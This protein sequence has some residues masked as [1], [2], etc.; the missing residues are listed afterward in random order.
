MSGLG[1]L[2]V[3]RTIRVRVPAST[4]NL[5]PGFDSIGLALGLWDEYLVTALDAPGLE[6][7]VTGQGSAD[8][9]TDESHLVVR[10][11]RHTWDVLEATAP[12]GLRLEAANGV[13]H[14]RGLGSSATAIVAGVVAA[15]AFSYAAELTPSGDVTVDLGVASH[16]AS[17]LEGHPDNASASVF[18]GLTVSWMPDGSAA[19]LSDRTVTARPVLHGD[20]DV[21]V[22]V[23]DHQLAT[24][25]ARAVLPTQVSLADAAANSGRAALLVHALTADPS[26]L[27]AAT[28][29]WLH[30]EPRRPSY[31]ETMRLVDALRARGHAAV[32]SG[33]GPTVL[34]LTTKDR[35]AAVVAPPEMDHWVRLT[36]GIATSG[37][38]VSLVGAG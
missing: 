20:V 8:V 14:G 16:I 15:Q 18:G 11:M 35:A 36:P 37:A 6:V 7:V 30:Q 25:T 3:G 1:P 21:V 38:T 31:A 17:V 34:V 29:D 33:A 4:A 22:F 5:G 32:V 9:P 10:T 23:P 12:A 24:R 26:H 28:R 2:G 27:H 13:P 19:D